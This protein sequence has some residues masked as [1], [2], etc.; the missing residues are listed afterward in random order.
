MIGF[1]LMQVHVYIPEES[2]PDYGT[3]RVV[4]KDSTDVYSSASDEN[5]LDSGTVASLSKVC[6]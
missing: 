4:A 3:V 1:S 2:H 5:W 6:I